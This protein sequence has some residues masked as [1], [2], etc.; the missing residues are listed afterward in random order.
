M[1][2]KIDKIILDELETIRK[3][4][5]IERKETRYWAH[6]RAIKDYDQGRLSLLWRFKKKLGILT[7]SNVF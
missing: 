5:Q 6:Y 7:F 3:L 1:K 2:V 4:K